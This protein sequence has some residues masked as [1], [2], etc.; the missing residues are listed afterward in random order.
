M[1]MDQVKLLEKRINKAI[2]FIENLKAKEN[3]L[4]N[5]KLKLIDRVN[6]LENISSEKQK[7]I[8]ELKKI[9]I[10]LK[11][12]I[13]VILDKLESIVEL[14][15]DQESGLE[16]EEN[17]VTS[18][19]SKNKVDNNIII[20]EDMVDL[21]NEKEKSQ[22]DQKISR[23]KVYNADRGED[24]SG[25]LT[26]GITE[27]SSLFNSKNSETALDKDNKKGKDKKENDIVG[28]SNQNGGWF[29]NNPF[30]EQ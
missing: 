15:D 28:D 2:K 13:E 19:E 27:E 25:F 9:Q 23:G 18:E 1:E 26:E 16:N 3:K 5:E 30:I 21:K 20:E 8:D 14:G 22:R 29:D 10:F 12:K 4:N 11:D 6:N 17:I 24:K 7:D